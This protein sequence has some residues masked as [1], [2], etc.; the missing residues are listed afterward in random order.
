MSVALLL[1]QRGAAL[2][3]RAL[4]SWGRVATGA[5]CLREAV[6]CAAAPP[7]QRSMHAAAASLGSS[8]HSTAAPGV[9]SPQQTRG[10]YAH[11]RMRLWHGSRVRHHC[12]RRRHQASAVDSDELGRP[13]LALHARQ[14]LFGAGG[15]CA[16][17]AAT[18]GR[19]SALTLRQVR[20]T[21]DLRCAYIRWDAVPGQLERT[22]RELARRCDGGASAC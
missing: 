1:R 3:L 5:M 17:A 15:A 8:A 18:V 6:A 12:S 13:G 20:M 9:L 7:Q 4:L 11:A 22:E 2:Q 16:H 10:M 21:P 19:G 14:R